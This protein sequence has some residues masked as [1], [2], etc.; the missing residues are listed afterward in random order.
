MR[1][2]PKIFPKPL[3]DTQVD[4]TIDFYFNMSSFLM[5]I[6]SLQSKKYTLHFIRLAFDVIRFTTLEINIWIFMDSVAS[7]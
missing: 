6:I 3:T 2:R 7:A 4:F 1:M 5:I